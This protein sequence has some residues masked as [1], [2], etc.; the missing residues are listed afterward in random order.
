MAGP[1]TTFD[2]YG[3]PGTA[4]GVLVSWRQPESAHDPQVAAALRACAGFFFVG[5]VQ[6]RVTAALRPGR[7]P[8]PAFDAIWQRW[9]EGAVV[10][11]SSAGAAIMSDPMIAGGSSAGALARGVRFITPTAADQGDQSDDTGVAIEPG[12]GFFRG[13]LVDQHFLARGRFAR[14]IV[15]V[16]ELEEFTLGFGTDENTALVAE[17]PR[18]W[19]VGASGV[20]IVDS[21]DA[22]RD[23]AGF[24][25][26]RLHLMSRGDTFDLDTRQLAIAPDKAALPPD[27]GDLQVP[28]DPL[29]PWALLHLLN[30]FGRSQSTEVVLPVPSGRMVLRKTADFRAASYAAPGV[31]GTPA[32]L[33]LTGLLLDFSRH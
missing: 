9:L 21:R 4:H 33:S 28:P 14:L 29:A 32:G 31:Q 27:P 23:S 5:G 11:G 15:A 10:S 22:Q 8:T 25:S 18:L 19:P 24:A 2:R 6:S 16:L 26:V 20:V 17:G 3:G 30:R 13:G 12:L 7:T 1:V